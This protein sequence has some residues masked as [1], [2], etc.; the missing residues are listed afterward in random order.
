MPRYMLQ[1]AYTADAWAA[2]AQNPQ[3]RS[4]PLGA[5]AEQLGGRLLS[6]DYCFGDYDGV[7]LLEAP[8][9]QTA[10]AV[11]IAAIAPGHVKATKTTRLMSV[12]ET[13]G[14]LRKAGQQSYRAPSATG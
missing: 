14:A 12:E 11:V 6:L 1:F 9:D 8:D 4:E 13:L 2:L 3:D 7:V 5:L 10:T